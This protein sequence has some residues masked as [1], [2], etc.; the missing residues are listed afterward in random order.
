MRPGRGR[1]HPSPRGTG[2][3]TLPDQEGLGHLLHGLTLLPHRDG[4]RGQADRAA[5]EQ[6]QQRLQHRA[7]QPVQAP[8]VHLVHREGRGGDVLG[9]PA[10]RLDLRVV[11]DAAQQAVGDAGVPRERP[12]ISAAPSASISTSSRLAE[13]W[14]TRSSSPGS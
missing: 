1:R 3:Q 14:T 5:A 12:A 6:F 8:G 10:V 7:V 4:E 9:D 13:R 11:P 2:E